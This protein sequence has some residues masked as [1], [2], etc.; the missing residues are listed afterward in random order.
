MRYRYYKLLFDRNLYF[1]VMDICEPSVYKFLRLETLSKQTLFIKYLQSTMEVQVHL[2]CTFQLW[3]TNFIG[4]RS[5]KI[6]NFFNHS[7]EFWLC[8]PF[9][10]V[11]VWYS[12][13]LFCFNCC[14]NDHLLLDSEQGSTVSKSFLLWLGWIYFLEE[15]PDWVG[16]TLHFLY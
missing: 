6:L 11:E 10:Y 16:R 13:V 3:W 15:C 7:F 8:F 12:N 14:N 1:K 9:V 2:Y 5:S 4:R